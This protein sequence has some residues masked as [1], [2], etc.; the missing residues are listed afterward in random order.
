MGF[1]L[2]ICHHYVMVPKSFLWAFGYEYIGVEE[3]VWRIKRIGQ[4]Y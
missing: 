4:L 2:D 3:K 1:D